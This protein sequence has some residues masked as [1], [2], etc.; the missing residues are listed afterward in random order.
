MSVLLSDSG[1]NKPRI[2]FVTFIFAFVSLDVDVSSLAP[3]SQKAAGRSL[4]ATRELVPSRDGRLRVAVCYWGLTRSTR[5]VYKTHQRRVFD[6]F[7][8]NGIAFDVFMHT[9]SANATFYWYNE[10]PVLPDKDE[11][12][13]LRPTH[14]ARDDQAEFLGALNFSDYFYKKDWDAKPMEHEWHPQLLRNHICALESLRRVTVMAK[15]AARHDLVL[16]IRPDT[17]IDTSIDVQWLRDLEHANTR[18]GG[19]ES[20][21]ILPNHGQYDGYNDQ[22]AVVH[23]KDCESYGARIER[24]A[25]YRSYVN[26]IIAERYLKFVVDNGFTN[27]VEVPFLFRTVKP[28]PGADNES[29]PDYLPVFNVEDE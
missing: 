7:T 10:F 12:K 9:W 1:N 5:Y 20:V 27:V 13:L 18:N 4:T 15:A 17:R 28:M 8:S 19:N 11:W 29:S 21:I 2:I 25:E 3:F 23:W 26:F 6:I 22:F 24:L 14:F 16:F